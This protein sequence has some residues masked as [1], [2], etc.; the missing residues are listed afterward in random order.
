[1]PSIRDTSKSVNT[2]AGFLLALIA[3]LAIAMV[4]PAAGNAAPVE[5]PQL[6]IEPGSY[7]FG[8]QPVYSG[9]QA[10]FQLRNEGTE[11][12]QI[13]SVEIV[14]PGSSA[15]WAGNCSWSWLQPG[16]SC[17]TQVNFNPQYVAEFEAELRVDVAGQ[18]F[19]AGLSGEGGQAILAP[20][21]SPADFGAVAVGS[22]GMTREI[23][24][25]NVG[26]MAGGAFIAVI[27]GGAV[28][29]FQLLDENCTGVPLAPAAT[30]TVQIRFRPLSEGAKKATLGLFGDREPAQVVLTGMGSAPEPELAW[31]PLEPHA[32]TQGHSAGSD[33]SVTTIVKKT[34]HRVTRPRVK[35]PKRKPQ[36]RHG[37][38][39][40]RRSG[41]AQASRLP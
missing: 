20:A 39:H 17:F 41:L 1:M 35:S 29:S 4:A 14:G 5:P 8:L 31:D 19:T 12:I 21:S 24:I 15:F 11:T 37:L 30:C 32:Q 18:Q 26:N 33:S 6:A 40:H 3:A 28:G 7:D 34:T 2:P 10:G 27:S 38:R 16:E 25:S 9:S 36:R 13:E 23:E 22:V